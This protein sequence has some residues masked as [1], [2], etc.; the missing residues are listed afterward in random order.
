MQ[1]AA[2]KLMAGPGPAPLATVLAERIRAHGRISFAEYMEACL[3]HPEY[4]YYTKADQDSR[5]DYFT[6]VD[7]RPLFGRL[8]ARQFFQMW[9]QLGRPASFALVEAGAGDGTL[10]KQILDFTEE[11]TPEFH[12]ALRYV[13]VERSAVR[14][15]AQAR[16]LGAHVVSGRAVLSADV[17]EQIA[18][19]CVFSNE[20]LDAM[21]VHRV[22]GPAGSEREI[23]VDL[24][25]DTLCAAIGKL[26]NA[27]LAGYLSAQRVALAEE[28]QAEI[29]LAACDWIEGIGARLRQG[30]VVT[31]DYGLEAAELYDSRHMRGTLL[32]YSRHRAGENYFQSPGRQDLTAH[33]NFTALERCGGGSGLVCAGFTSQANFLMA[34]ARHSQFADLQSDSMSEQEQAQARLLFKTLIHPEGMGEAFRVLIQHKGIETPHVAG[35]DAI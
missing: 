33:V 22:V 8:L 7:V 15:A 35:L 23:Y 16:L 18:C 25:G 14:Q 10:A 31:I 20:L 24:H 5:R 34:L 12:A 29:C 13:A 30:F 21:P 6:S 1:P 32:A 11:R 19:G 4:G 26:S 28:Q 2:G 27:R 17:P 9:E 3:Y